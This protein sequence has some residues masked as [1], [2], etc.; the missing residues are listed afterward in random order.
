MAEETNQDPSFE[1][2]LQKLLQHLETRR[3]YYALSATEK[4]SGAAA[5]LSGMAIIFVFALI[6]LFFFSIG[7]AVWLGDVIHNRAGGFVL[8]G[9]IF[10]PIAIIAYMKVPGFVRS[11]IIQNILEDD[12]TDNKG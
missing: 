2:L 5:M 12:D 10:V 9:L 7:F 11:K 8:A 3:E 6:I 4:V 1:R